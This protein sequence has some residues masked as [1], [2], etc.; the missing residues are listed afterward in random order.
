VRRTLKKSNLHFH[1][2]VKRLPL[3]VSS[4]FR[5]WGEGRTIYVQRG[6]GARL[7]DIDGNEY[8]DYRLGYGPAIL[9]Y[10][11][12]RVDAAARAGIEVGGIFALGTELELAVAERIARMV[13]AAELVRFSNSGTEA[14]MTALRV[15]RAHSG[16]DGYIMVEGGYHGLSDAFQ[17]GIE[18]L[19]ESGG[20]IRP[21]GEGVP[22]LLRELFHLVPLN[23]ADRLEDV[24][25]QHGD[26]IGA[27]LIEPI[28]GNCCSISADPQ[29]M[30]DVRELCDR[31]GVVMI[32]DEV[33]TGFRVAR[34][35]VQELIGVKADVCTFAKAVANGY[36][37]S[38]V[39]GREDIMR[40]IGHGVV[41]GGTYTAHSVS[42]AAAD[43]TLEILETTDA[44]ER[45]ADY[46]KRMQEGFR[47]VLSHRGIAHCFTGHPAM[48]GLIF[49]ESPP[50]NYR[51]W[52]L[53]DY[54]FYDA[55][56]PRLHDRGIL[57]EP[58]SREPWMV[59]A[60]HDDECLARTLEAFEGAVEET[61]RS[62]RRSRKSIPLAAGSPEEPARRKRD[63]GEPAP[64]PPP[65]EP[66]PTSASTPRL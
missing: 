15:A 53:S 62:F 2:A 30:R 58:D 60:A 6:Q 7:W 59:S 42:I 66:Y 9:G 20:M 11:D 39:A 21:Y 29:Y 25:R 10:A 19:E 26:E 41:H 51:E 54:T 63:K 44:L 5:Y 3:G 49:A 8:I 37:I 65:A 47:Q 22:R 38:V 14:V 13:P 55:L 40:R 64:P 35:G 17:W 12:P 16:R 31:Y 57:C 61:L 56:A 24:L 50:R 23:D 45:V 36:P 27:L 43:K 34:G 32:V 4:N 48:G 33:K 18:D 46:G 1:R 52:A 28:L